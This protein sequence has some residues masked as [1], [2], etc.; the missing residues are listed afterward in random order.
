M[1]V[2][3]VIILFGVISVF[4]LKM[5]RMEVSRVFTE[6]Y[7]ELRQIYSKP[8]K[9]W[10]FLTG[11]LSTK[12]VS[13]FLFKGTLKVDVYLD[14]LIVSAIGQGIC[15]HYGQYV[16]KQKRI[17]FSNYLIVEN[18]PV[19]ERGNNI[20]GFGKFS[21][22]KISLSAKKIDMILKLASGNYRI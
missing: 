4:A 15:L 2:I 17:L 3:F 1:E 20:L 7:K 5:I 11:F 22:L 18:L 9:T 13:P 8:L 10:R 21:T 14:M 19:Q 16:F 12:G 6:N